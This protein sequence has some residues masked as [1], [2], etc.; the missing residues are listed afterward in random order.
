[1]IH[2]YLTSIF[3]PILFAIVWEANSKNNPAYV[4]SVK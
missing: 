4:M 2:K 3:Y 1:M